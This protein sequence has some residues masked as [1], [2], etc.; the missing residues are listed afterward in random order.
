L[1]P[2]R[3]VRSP[4]QNPFYT[5]KIPFDVRKLTHRLDTTPH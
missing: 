1:D 2:F 3:L 5:P 4:T